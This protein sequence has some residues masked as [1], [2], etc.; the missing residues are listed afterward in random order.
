MYAVVNWEEVRKVP[1]PRPLEKEVV[2]EVHACGICGS[3]IGARK[4]RLQNVHAD[5]NMPK[6]IS[7]HEFSGIITEVGEDVKGWKLGDRVIVNPMLYCGK[8]KYCK[9]GDTNLCDKSDCMGW[10]RNGG[11]AEK[12][13][14]PD[15][16]LNFLP[17]GVSFEIGALVDPIGVDVHA[18]DLIDLVQIKTV[19]VFGLG[20]IGFPIANMLNEKC[21]VY[22]VDVVPKKLEI[23]E[24]CGLRVINAKEE[25]IFKIF[26]NEEIDLCVEAVGGN[27]PTFNQA[28]EILKKRGMLLS[29]SVR[30]LFKMKYPFLGNKEI[31]IQGVSAHTPRAFRQVI[32]ILNEKPWVQKM[33][34]R[35][36]KL[37]DFIEAITIAGSGQELKVMVNI[38]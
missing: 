27:S 5:G 26:R 18:L 3:D 7:G 8:C 12:V 25:N 28:L 13:A 20:G 30:G 11:F 2:V 15:Y 4:A 17:E 29:I 14:V 35:R 1:E 34:T 16:T 19:V 37:V 32:G 6:V 31:R 23:A 33:I 10:A 36:Y 9:A 38:K 24:K 21:K 22:G